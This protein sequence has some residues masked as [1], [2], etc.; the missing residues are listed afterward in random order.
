MMLRQAAWAGQFYPADP[1]ELSRQLTEF[2]S[3]APPAA[4]KGELVGLMV[5]HA[6][7]AYSGA[8]AGHA[9]RCLRDSGIDFQRVLLLGNAHHAPVEGGAVYAQGRW[10][11]PLGELGVDE[12]AAGELSLLPGLRDDAA[13][14]LP[15]HCLEVQLPFLQQ[16]LPG[17]TIIPILLGPNFSPQDEQSLAAALA[18]LAAAKPTLIIASS[19]MSHFPDSATARLVDE[20]TLAVISSLDARALER[21]LAAASSAGHAGLETALCGDG[22]VKLMLTTCKLLGACDAKVLGYTNSGELTGESGR[23][24]GYGALAVAKG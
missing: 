9:Y 7:Y 19:D 13:P 15:E 20:A 14:H 1:A 11:T 17:A 22:A 4:L 6:G 3:A 10:A 21:Q 18:G 5:P 23:A 2:V 24:V 16:V 12:A 8:L